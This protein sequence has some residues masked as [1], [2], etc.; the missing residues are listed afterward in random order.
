[1]HDM[2]AYIE[3][4]VENDFFWYGIKVKWIYIAP[5]HETSKALTH[6]SRSVTCNQADACLYL[7]S[8]HQMAPLHTEVANI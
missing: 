6:R 8:V 4:V 5:S 1:M 7:V 3:N 2:E